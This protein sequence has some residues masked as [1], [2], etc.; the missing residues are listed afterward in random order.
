MGTR[1]GTIDPVNT[2]VMKYLIANGITDGRKKVAVLLS[3]IGGPTYDLLCDLFTSEKPNTKT[4]NELVTKLKDHLEPK[5][6]VIVER[7]K[8][9]QRQQKPDETV[10]EHT[11]SSCHMSV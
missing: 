3:V 5:P 4:F 11:T 2:V 7:Y 10:S 9:Y 8:L 6:T 1:I